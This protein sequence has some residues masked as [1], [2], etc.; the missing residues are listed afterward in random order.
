MKL[1]APTYA[2]RQ[3]HIMVDNT[4][5]HNRA[6]VKPGSFTSVREIPEAIHTLIDGRNNRCVS[7]VRAKT[8]DEILE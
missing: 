2:R 7:F 4:D 5:A 1:V 3:L 6:D 8:V